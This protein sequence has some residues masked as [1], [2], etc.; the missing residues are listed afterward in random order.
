M[1]SCDVI[2]MIEGVGGSQGGGG[3][4]KFKLDNLWQIPHKPVS[5]YSIN[6]PYLIFS[7][8]QSTEMLKTDNI[9]KF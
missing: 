8:M 1:L 7:E 4:R 2:G 5:K 6:I 9:S 3:H